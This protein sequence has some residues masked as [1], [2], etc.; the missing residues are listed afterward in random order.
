MP[1]FSADQ[2]LILVCAAIGIACVAAA[3]GWAWID[4]L[5]YSSREIAAVALGIVGAAFCAGSLV[6]HRFLTLRT[7][8]TR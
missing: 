8:S 5:R 4:S 7:P 6:L 3:A 1:T 2:R